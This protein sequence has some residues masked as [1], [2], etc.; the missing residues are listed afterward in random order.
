M[1]PE[2]EALTAAL[3]P[4]R[5]RRAPPNLRQS[6]QERFGEPPRRKLSRFVYPVAAA[7]AGAALA[8]GV[9]LG[10][11]EHGASQALFNEAVSDHLRLLYAERPVEIASGGVHQ[12]KPWFAGRID[13][14]PV[15]SFGGDDEFPLQGGAVALFL[16]RKAAAF[17]YRRRLHPVT[18]LVFRAEGLSFPRPSR[19]I[20]G[21]QVALR[22]ERGFNVLIWRRDDLGYA[23]VSD[24]D[25]REL[26]LLAAKLVGS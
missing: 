17:E 5:E 24:L 8:L 26:S 1:T 7:L 19:A 3:R 4:L 13:F 25:E 2:D 16:D 11:R 23:L 15:V 18:L 14:A 12:V 21:A 10:V 6:L 20:G 22:R 9:M